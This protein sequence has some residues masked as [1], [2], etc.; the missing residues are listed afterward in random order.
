VLARAKLAYKQWVILHRNFPRTERYG[1]GTKIDILLLELLD[2][3]RK[4]AYVQRDQKIK[5]LESALDKIDSLRFFIQLSWELQ[6]I[7]NKQFN[8]LGGTIEEIGKMLGGWKKSIITKTS[9]I[10]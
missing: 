10:R 1:M 4:A 6:A 9:A 2:L 3:L 8:N 5:L 7:S